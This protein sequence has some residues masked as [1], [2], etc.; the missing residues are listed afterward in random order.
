[1]NNQFYSS[2]FYKQDYVESEPRTTSTAAGDVVGAS[3]P[4]ENAKGFNFIAK[5]TGGSALNSTNYLIFKNIEFGNDDFSESVV[6]DIN[7]DYILVAGDKANV[8]SNLKLA[9]VG[10]FKVGIPNLAINGQTRVR[11]NYTVVGSAPN[12]IWESHCIKTNKDLP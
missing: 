7:S 8:L 12:I 9:A 3:I 6:Y 4:V 1:M 10:N 2:D 11:A 5:T